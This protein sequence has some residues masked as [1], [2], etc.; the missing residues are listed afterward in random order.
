MIS[1]IPSSQ[2]VPNTSSGST[3]TVLALIAIGLGVLAYFDY[4][5]W[6]IVLNKKAKEAP[7]T[8]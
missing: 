6:H 4:T 5:R 7:K 2:I 8:A 1:T 3:G